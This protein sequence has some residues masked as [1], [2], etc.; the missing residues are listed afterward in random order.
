MANRKSGRPRK[1]IWSSTGPTPRLLFGAFAIAAVGLLGL[2]PK[3]MFGLSIAWPYAAL[4]G[5][6]GWGR[7]GMSLRP[8]ILLI[9]FGL[10]QDISFNAPLGCFVIVNLVVYGFSA[11][12]AGM[13]D[14]MNEPLVAIIAPVLQFISGFL[15]L[16]LMASALEDH[17][18][19]AT[20]LFA[21]FL[22]TGVIYAACHRLFDLGRAPGESV[23]Q[24][25]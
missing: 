17:A 15:V 4:W 25:T 13:F 1:S 5:A 8:M 9:A 19:R 7:V 18:V 21:A 20:P 14:V 23:G 10:I 12:I 11:W 22:T 2:T 16:W 6:V 24:A 3:T